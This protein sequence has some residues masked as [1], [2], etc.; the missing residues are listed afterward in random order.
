MAVVSDGEEL[1][2][3]MDTDARERTRMSDDAHCENHDC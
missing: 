2:K 3:P 1:A